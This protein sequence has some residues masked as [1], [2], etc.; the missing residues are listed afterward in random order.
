MK[1]LLL[2]TTTLF[3]F[4][5]HTSGYMNIQIYNLASKD[6]II[7]G[8]TIH[9]C[10]QQNGN[11]VCKQKDNIKYIGDYSQSFGF[12]RYRRGRLY[13]KPKREFQ[14]LDAIKIYY[15][16]K[17]CLVFKYDE[18]TNDNITPV[19]EKILYDK[20][21]KGNGIIV[22]TKDGLEIMT[23]EQYESNK[24]RYTLNDSNV[25]CLNGAK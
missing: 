18:Y 1:K 2:F 7:E 20:S 17:S 12:S 15:K 13:L 5:C 11:T 24:N 16:S 10:F 3:I 19:Y 9:H 4:S 8:R 21:Y 25:R 6:I 22:L 23:K 14:D